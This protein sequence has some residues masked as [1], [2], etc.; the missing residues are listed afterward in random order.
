MKAQSDCSK[1]YAHMKYAL[2]YSESAL[3]TN[4][5]EHTKHF[6]ERSK[7]AFIQAQSSLNNCPCDSVEDMVN[8]AISYL[9]KVNSTKALKEA[10]YYTNKGQKL[11]NATI[12]QLDNCTESV[13]GFAPDISIEVD[14]TI[15]ELASIEAVQNDLLEQQESLKLKQTELK[16]RLANKKQQELTI[17]KEE[18]INKLEV[19]VN[20]NVITFN[21]ALDACDCQ[22]E[23]LKTTFKKEKLHKQSLV[24]IKTL[25]I[26]I[27]KE[28]TANYLKQ[29]NDCKDN[30]STN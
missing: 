22:K 29:L 27:I 8:D 2:S 7:A 5:I 26:D 3:E 25:G 23:V 17:K 16:Q 1:A 11:A 18:L 21:N 30:Q 19:T 28:L 10:F 4:N 14:N 24:E 20:A 6:A 12:A 15:E 13:K 9:S